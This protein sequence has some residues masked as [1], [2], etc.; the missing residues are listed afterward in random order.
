[1]KK[2][3]AVGLKM[4]RNRSVGWGSGKRTCC[5]R[6][7]VKADANH[8]IADIQATLL[9]DINRHTDRQVARQ[10]QRQMCVVNEYA[11]GGRRTWG[12][13]DFFSCFR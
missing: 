10:L 3:T 5:N 2:K 4:K 7:A 12:V 1:M 9:M 11:C 6:T 13:S 8:Q